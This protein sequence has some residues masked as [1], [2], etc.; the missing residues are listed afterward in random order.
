M[1]VH[2]KPVDASSAHTVAG[3]SGGLCETSVNSTTGATFTVTAWVGR[4]VKIT[5]KGDGVF[6]IFSS[7]ATLASA[8]SKTAEAL[9][10][11]TPGS[12]IPDY[13]PD[14][15]PVQEVVPSAKTGEPVYLHVVAD[16]GT[17]AVRV[18]KA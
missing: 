4:Y 7:E 17:A 6:Y 14:G 12:T 13:T 15:V 8:L 2:E 16:T 18:R 5:P 3:A 11:E 10:A 9:D 1:A